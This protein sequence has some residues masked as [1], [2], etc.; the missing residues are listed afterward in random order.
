MPRHMRSG[1][2]ETTATAAPGGGGMLPTPRPPPLHLGGCRAGHT[3]ASSN[4][5]PQTLYPMGRGAGAGRRA[6]KLRLGI[7]W[8]RAASTPRK[9]MVPSVT[10]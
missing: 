5:K 9:F 6:W 10:P 8:N 2:C 3:P 4:P 1:T 7:A